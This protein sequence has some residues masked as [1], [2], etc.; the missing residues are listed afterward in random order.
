MHSFGAVIAKVERPDLSDLNR[1]TLE[2][3]FSLADC[4]RVVDLDFDCYVFDSD[5]LD[6]RLDKI[7]DVCHKLSV[8]RRTVNEFCDATEH[9]LDA[10]AK[11]VASE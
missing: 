4:N 9:N 8:L 11:H 5:T 6:E 2:A 10:M 3:S 7:E 1:A